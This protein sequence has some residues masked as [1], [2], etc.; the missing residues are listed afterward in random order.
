MYN[1]KFVPVEKRISVIK[2]IRNSDLGEKALFYEFKQFLAEKHLL[3]AKKLLND[4]GIKVSGDVLVS[5]SLDEQWAFPNA[6][7]N[8]CKLKWGIIPLN[9][10]SPEGEKLL[11]LKIRNFARRFDGLRI[12][13]AWTYVKQPLKLIKEK[14]S[15]R[16]DYYSRILNLIDDEIIKTKG[17]EYDTQ[18]IMYEFMADRADFTMYN[19]NTLKPYLKNRLKIL[20]TNN[21]SEDWNTVTAYRNR[22]WD[23][24]SYILGTTNHD[25]PPL[26]LNYNEVKKSNVIDVLIDILKLPKN[27]IKTYGDFLKAKFAEPMR[28]KHNM[29]FF[30]EALNILERY[31]DNPG[32]NRKNDYRVKIPMNYKEIYFSALEK[33]EGFNVMDA[34]EKAFVAEGLDKTEQK[35]FNKIVK[36][37]KILETPQRDK[38]YF[39]RKFFVFVGLLMLILTTMSFLVKNNKLKNKNINR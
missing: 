15:Y 36:Y 16:V 9:L 13:A 29:I 3:Q 35:L 33:G 28:A 39:S 24:S 25:S 8:D 31:K 32:Q 2:A 17:V 30:T 37:R 5:I 6:T 14:I 38:K 34:L 27:S 20:T 4:K 26:R 21:I 12:D 10:D 1:E 19:E 22:G 7:Y 18:N 23:P 11:R